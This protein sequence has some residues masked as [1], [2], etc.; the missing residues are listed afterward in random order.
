MITPAAAREPRAA[1]VPEESLVGIVREIG[2]RLGWRY[3]WHV[4]IWVLVALAIATVWPGGYTSTPI[5]LILGGPVAVILI[6]AVGARSAIKRGNNKTLVRMVATVVSFL[7]SAG[8][9]A[10]GAVARVLEATIRGNENA[11]IFITGDGKGQDHTQFIG[12][13][14]SLYLDFGLPLLAVIVLVC[15]FVV[16]RVEPHA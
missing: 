9:I 7:V 13:N 3:W 16:G 10:L 4:A 12:L 6:W 15:W 5:P 14:E 8:S 11:R 2:G 1:I